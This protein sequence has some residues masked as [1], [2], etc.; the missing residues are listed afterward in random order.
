MSCVHVDDVAGLILHAIESESVSG[1]LNAVL[2]AP[3][4]NADFN[5]AVARAVHRPAFIPAPAFALKLGLGELSHLLLDSQR[6]LPTA[7]LS[8]GYAF[9]HST[10]ESAARASVR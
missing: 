4:R 6:V 3:L 10:I 8:T 1:P 9:Q 7:T 5:R 2:P